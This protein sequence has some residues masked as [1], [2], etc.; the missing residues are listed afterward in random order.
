MSTPLT[1][2]YYAKFTF[3]FVYPPWTPHLARLRA[4]SAKRSQKGRFS[5]APSFP[6]LWPCSA[7]PRVPPRM[8]ITLYCSHFV[9]SSSSVSSSS[10]G[11]TRGS[12]V[13]ANQSSD[14]RL[15]SETLSEV[16]ITDEEPVN[17][18]VFNVNE[19]CAARSGPMIDFGRSCQR[20]SHRLSLEEQC[21]F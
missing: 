6:F 19:E 1:Q 21:Q 7:C 18:D 9:C 8:T 4:P 12:T 5:C 17:D 3:S 20:S 16:K 10:E 15:E 13:S 2:S 14:T 11:S